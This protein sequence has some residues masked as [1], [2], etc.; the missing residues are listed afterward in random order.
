MADPEVNAARFAIVREELCRKFSN[1]LHKVGLW[2]CA[3]EGG[4]EGG[5]VG[6]GGGGGR[7]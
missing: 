3:G 5:R 6:R 1:E 7:Q 2:A 4:G